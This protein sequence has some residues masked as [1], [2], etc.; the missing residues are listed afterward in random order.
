MM[1]PINYSLPNKDACIWISP[2]IAKGPRRSPCRRIDDSSGYLTKAR[3]IWVNPTYKIIFFGV[4]GILIPSTSDI[5]LLG[6]T[7]NKNHLRTTN[8]PKG[9]YSLLLSWPH[10][11]SSSSYF[12]LH[13]MGNERSINVNDSTRASVLSTILPS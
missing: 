5:L 4:I 1:N 6:R 7:Y 3:G 10:E 2:M 11:N 12:L 9:P 8:R 13:Q